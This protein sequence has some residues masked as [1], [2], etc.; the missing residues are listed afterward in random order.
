MPAYRHAAY[1][2]TAI[3]GVLTQ[4]LDDWELIV[5]DDASPDATWEVIQGFSEPR[6][7]AI[8]HDVNRG[9]HHTINEGLKLARG[10]Y[11][12]I[13]NSD[14]V[15]YPERLARTID[16]LEMSQIDL[17]GTDIDLIDENG[18][19]VRDPGHWWIQWYGQLKRVY[20]ETGDLL[21]VLLAGNV[22]ITTSNFVFRRRVF[23]VLGGFRDFRYVHDYDFLL[24]GLA[25]ENLRLHFETTETLLAYR[26]HAANTIQESALQANRETFS[27]LTQWFPKYLPADKR[28]AAEVFCQ[29]LVR[30]EGYIEGELEALSQQCAVHGEQEQLTSSVDNAKTPG[31]FWNSRLAAA[32]VSPTGWLRRAIRWLRPVTTASCVEELGR[33]I[34]TM[35]GRVQVVSF[36]VFDT[37]LA[38]RID[39]PEV[40][41]ERVAEGFAS[42][43]G[44]GLEPATLLRLRYDAERSLRAAAGGAGKDWECHHD[45]LLA[46]WVE[47]AVGAADARLAGQLRE[48]ELTLEADALRVKPGV[49]DLL[50]RL[51]REGFRLVATSDMYLGCDNVTALLEKEG[52][53]R[54]LDRI[55]VSADQG[56]CKGSGRL[57]ELVLSDQSCAP[58]DLLHVG[59]NLISDYH[60]PRARGIRVIHLHEPREKKRRALVR[61]YLDLG[62]RDGYWR[63]R[64]LL[65]IANAFAKNDG[66]QER[67][68]DF[69]YGRDVLGP[70]FCTA[71]LKALER[72]R[73]I[74]PSKVYFL[75]R[76]GHIF[77]VLYRKMASALSYT[78]VPQV[79]LHV[80]RQ[81]AFAAS[82]ADG[83]THEQ[84]VVALHN[85]S[86]EGLLSILKVSGLDPKEFKELAYQHGFKDL[87]AALKNWDDARVH[88]FL[89]DPRVQNA[90][91]AH[92]RRA[93]HLLER[94]LEQFD[95]FTSG[96]KVLMDIGWNATIQYGVQQL[97]RWRNG[98]ATMWGLYFGFCGGIP[99]A[100]SERSHVEGLIYDE[101]RAN[102]AERLTMAFEEVFE[103]GARASHGTTIGYR[104]E[105]SRVLPI[106]KRDDAP[107]RAR[108]LAC[109]ARIDA[110]QK[111]ILDFA[112]DF[113]AAV[114]LTG[115]TSDEIRPFM[116]TLLERAMA[117]PTPEEVYELRELAHADDFGHDSVMDFRGLRPTRINPMRWRSYKQELKRSP[118]IFAMLR[119]LPRVYYR[120]R[121]LAQ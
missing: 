110:M 35:R 72:I 116:L 59:D 76:D 4:T 90:A 111:G 6:L 19:V 118:W 36:D 98:S 38:R 97:E 37:L 14:D 91:K 96:D 24:R 77:Q 3:R 102:E 43:L 31:R 75:A 27:I 44:T 60:A 109:N 47:K 54:F 115:Y 15:Y 64:C 117:Y 104:A 81:V 41:H 101:R 21:H 68:F 63:G 52:V 23:E 103:E 25:A 22:F 93:Q 61:Q 88:A 7:Q 30:V 2:G 39:P 48:L 62:R 1:V 8:R 20:Q 94:Y 29:H 53:A 99:Y 55:Y 18:L 107:D 17:L 92:G 67:D 79:Y 114:R 120:F 113:V 83:L 100:F 105:G 106:L 84:A 70:L 33:M 32:L 9:V 46:L 119:G 57:F 69:A 50:A 80:S 12:A 45:E 82:I 78:E 26:L 85:P 74:R 13:L 11:L 34:D 121:R 86:Q 28:A 42:M 112:S 73:Q 49:R 87:S 51:K 58:A 65:Q 89:K 56:L 16:R 66:P 40:V 5:I 10:E 108:E 95:F 71:T